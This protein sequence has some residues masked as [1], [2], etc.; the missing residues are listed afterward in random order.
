VPQTPDG[1]ATSVRRPVTARVA[2]LF[3]KYLGAP[4]GPQ[5][6]DLAGQV[7]FAGTHT[8]VS[9]VHGV[10]LMSATISRSHSRRR[11]LTR[12]LSHARESLG[13]TQA[14]QGRGGRRTPTFGGRPCR[15]QSPMSARAARS[16]V[17]HKFDAA[18][19]AAGGNACNPRILGIGADSGHHE[20]RSPNTSVA[21]DARG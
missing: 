2:R 17:G 6:G 8:G 14:G 20:Q 9:E 4:S 12:F 18:A 1:A 7:L 10:A 13:C 11:H 15:H 5:F 19:V 21:T 3:G 16:P